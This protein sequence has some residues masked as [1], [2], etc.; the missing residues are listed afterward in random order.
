MVELRN[1]LDEKNSSSVQ[2]HQLEQLVMQEKRENE[3]LRDHV[4]QM[5][6]DIE[7]DR[8]KRQQKEE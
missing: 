7:E 4:E 1:L 5:Q 8:R 6:K 3:T 2:V